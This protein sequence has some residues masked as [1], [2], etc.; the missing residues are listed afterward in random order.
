[1]RRH[2]MTALFG[3]LLFNAAILA[4]ESELPR[5]TVSHGPE[6]A[7]PGFGKRYSGRRS[8]V[9]Q[10]AA[11]YQPALAA[12][13]PQRLSYAF[14]M[15]HPGKGDRTQLLV[16]TLCRTVRRCTGNIGSFTPAS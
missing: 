5:A 10:E 11:G 13:H 3:S 4:A 14:S 1:M 6:M 12:A 7:K 8:G 16:N 2:F 15:E 9:D